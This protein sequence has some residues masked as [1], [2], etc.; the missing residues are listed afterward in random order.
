MSNLKYWGYAIIAWGVLDF[1]LSYAGTEV[2]SEWPGVQLPAVIWT[3]SAMIAVA[4]GYG[5]IKLSGSA[6]EDPAG[7]ES[8]A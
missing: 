4:I 3:C 2:W 5:V 7:E 1:G 6:E 8:E